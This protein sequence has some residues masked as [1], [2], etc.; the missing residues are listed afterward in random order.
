MVRP[1]QAAGADPSWLGAFSRDF[2]KRFLTLLSFNFRAFPSITALSVDEAANAGAKLDEQAAS[3]LT[4][5]ELDRYMSPFDLKRLESYANNML[6]YHVILDLLPTIANLYFT[7][8]LKADVRLTPVQQAILLAVGQQRKDM[9]AVSQELALPN[10]QLLAMFIKI[11]RKV[12]AHFSSLVSAAVDAE[13]PRPASLGVSR[14]NAQGVHEDEVVDARF[15]P[16]E[17]ALDDELDEGGDEVARELKRKQRELID[18][19]PLDQYEIDGG[20]AE[21]E[22]AE[23]QIAKTGQA[24]AVVS[25]KT[26]K[27]KR[28]AGQ[29]TAAEVY[30]E[31][32]GERKRKPKKAKK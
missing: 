31:A 21:W 7:G 20:A 25:V 4:K 6:D 1:L 10:Q 2:Q 9:D 23:K 16:L 3:P 28:K 17:T 8:R 18:S 22:D 27:A 14:E 12:T 26:A 13:L 30:E 24:G 5:T 15:E 29:Q 32:F 11:L 19:L